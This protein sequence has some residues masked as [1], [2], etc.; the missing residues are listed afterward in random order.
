MVLVRLA[1]WRM[2][3]SSHGT[4]EECYI[5]KDGTCRHR[6]S[7]K[8]WR[9]RRVAAQHILIYLL[10]VSGWVLKYFSEALQQCS[11][12]AC[13]ARCVTCSIVGASLAPLESLDGMDGTQH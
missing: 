4:L 10:S 5:T 13:T 6:L 8:E 1:C 12:I 9:G 2:N 7:R 3:T 11:N